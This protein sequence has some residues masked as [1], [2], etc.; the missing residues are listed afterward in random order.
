MNTF[1]LVAGIGCFSV[2]G[3]IVGYVVA[4]MRADVEPLGQGVQ[5]SVMMDPPRVPR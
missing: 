5:K 4:S 1:L 2:A 3:F